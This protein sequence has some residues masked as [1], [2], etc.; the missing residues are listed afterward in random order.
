[1]LNHFYSKKNSPIQSLLLESSLLLNAMFIVILLSASSLVSAQEVSEANPEAN[2]ALDSNKTQ[3]PEKFTMNMRE[4]D[5][6]SFVQWVAD[7]TQKNIILH[8]NVRGNVTV[9]SSRAVS[10]EEAYE[11]FLTVLQLNGF[12]AVESNN[13]VKVIPDADAK[14]SDV[15][16]SGFESKQG[17]IVTSIIDLKHSD[18]TQFVSTL[19]PLVP[20]SSHLAAYPPTNALI[21]ADTARGITKIKELVA[22]LDKSDAGFDLEIVPIIHASAE[23]IKQVIEAVVNIKNSAK[24]GEA[25]ANALNFAVDKRSNS[26]LITGNKQK[27]TQIKRLIKKL[28]VPLNGDGNT[29][30]V[31]LNYI[32]AK[33]IA[34]ILQNVAASI[35]KEN[36]TEGLKSFSIDASEATNSLVISAPPALMQSLK[37][38]ISKLDIQ[39]AQVL[40]EAVV[41]QVQG[42]A[43]DALGLIGVGSDIYEGDRSGGIGAVNLQGSTGIGTAAASIANDNSTSNLVA[44]LAGSAGISFGYLED[45]NLIA[46][47]RA[48]TSR[49]RSNIM[50]TPTI[51]ALDNEEASLLVGQN[52]PFITGSSTSSGADVTNPFQTVERQDVGI[53]L[54]VTPR[55]NQGDSITLDINQTTENVVQNEE[56]GAVDL[57]TEKT[58]ITTSALIKDGQVLVLG[59]LIRE[60]DVETHSQVPLL[61][62]IPIIGRVFRSHSTDKAKNNLMVFIRP[63]ILKEQLQISGLTAQRYAFMREKQMR[64]ALDSFINYHKEKPLLEEFEVFSPAG[65]LPDQTSSN[66]SA[67][68]V[69]ESKTLREEKKQIE[70]EPASSVEKKKTL[71]RK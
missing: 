24:K 70:D 29:Q 63:I 23:E 18:A 4:A 67:Q 6:R 1:M 58:E 12:A 14:T 65:K 66:Y 35:Q 38:V 27:R 32:E 49:N 31:Y 15:P 45:G 36:K 34:P 71:F 26:L 60:D 8:R 13:V 43:Q 2:N 61:G 10:P 52:V 47:L 5:I 17:E 54:K 3:E 46:A 68:P 16:F 33:E 40:I 44:N 25:P 9:I 51:V 48:V 62:D 30:V 19:R 11:L 28:D 50:S 57:V 41:V 22:I 37:S 59:G 21:V 20:A 42:N 64:E 55:I 7:R 53:T 39:R 56:S 69:T